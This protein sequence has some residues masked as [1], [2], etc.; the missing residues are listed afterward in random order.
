MPAREVQARARLDLGLGGGEERCAEAEGD[1]TA[2]DREAQ[3]EQVRRRRDRAPDER[4]R[5]SDQRRGRVPRVPPGDARD[6]RPR[7]LR[8][9]TAAPAAHTPSPLGF[10]DDVTDVAGVA[11][12]AVQ[13]TTAGH[14]AAA[15][16]GRHDHADV[17]VDAPG[18]ARPAFAERECLG[19]VVEEHRQPAPLGQARPQ[20]EPA[21]GR[22]VERRDVLTVARHRAAASHTDGARAPCRLVELVDEGGEHAEDLLGVGGRRC[23]RIASDEQRAVVAHDSRRELRSSDV[24]GEDVAHVTRSPCASRGRRCR[25]ATGAGRTGRRRACCRACRCRRPRT[26]E[27][28]AAASRARR[29]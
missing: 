1:R 11:E 10:D 22:D 29:R 8:L 14:D 17:V 26:R 15:H 18:R 23:R 3:V 16:S 25:P 9:Q 21:P 19:V 28:A 4:A 27:R 2:H 12:G 5:P 24:D 7:G 13:E 6:R 20:R